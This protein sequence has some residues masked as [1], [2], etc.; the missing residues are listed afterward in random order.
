MF[1][2]ANAGKVFWPVDL[3]QVD[4]D[5]S[6]GTATVHFLYQLMTSKE[7]REYERAALTRVNPVASAAPTL[8]A[9]PG[10][11][12]LAF[13]DAAAAVQEGDR[14]ML[15]NRIS[16]WRGIANGD[17]PVEFTRERLEAL[18]SYDVYFKRI[19]EGLFAASREAPRK[20]LQPGSGGMPAPAQA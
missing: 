2:F 8:S 19:R 6:V 9:A 4:D 10:D 11:S 13:L 3:R 15:L 12:M 7:L 20:N 18:L 1:Q 5:G 17:E 16:D 14:E